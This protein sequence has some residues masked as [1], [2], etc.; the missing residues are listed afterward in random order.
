MRSN[1]IE[2]KSMEHVLAALTPENALV[3][4]VC[5]RYGLRVGD[6]LAFKPEQVVQGR[7]TVTEQKT[8]KK[9][10]IKI[11]GKLQRDLLAQA[12]LW[13]V[14]P[15][16]V[17]PMKHRTRQAVWKDVKRAAVAFRFPHVSPHSARKIFAVSMRARG[18][19]YAEIQAKLNHSD[20]ATTLIYAL[21]DDIA[22]QGH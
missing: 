13:W 10:R 22:P 7:F 18:F 16:R 12:G 4:R 1:W 3:M 9:R 19:S 8:G 2:P 17:D 14:F 11:G 6:V 15:G 20:L 5:L 21:A